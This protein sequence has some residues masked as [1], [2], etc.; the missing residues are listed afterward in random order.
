M[1]P[2][3]A[4]AGAL[5]R[6]IRPDARVRKPFGGY[7]KETANNCRIDWTTGAPPVIARSSCDEAT[8]GPR[9]AAPGL[10][11][12]ARNDGGEVGSRMQRF[13]VTVRPRHIS[14][15]KIRIRARVRPMGSLNPSPSRTRA[16]ISW[17]ASTKKFG[18]GQMSFGTD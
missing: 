13:P 1:R 4:N 10:L 17:A 12:C 6:E 11:R 18:R 7:A 16:G 8:Q 9:D 5:G 14:L 3:P 15:V 2:L